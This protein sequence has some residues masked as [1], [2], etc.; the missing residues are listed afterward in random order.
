M[1]P[2]PKAIVLLSIYSEISLRCFHTEHIG[3]FW[4]VKSHTN[5]AKCILL[6]ETPQNLHGSTRAN[7]VNLT[8]WL[9]ALS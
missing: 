5:D 4:R 1:L 3:A 9:V 6:A 8:H 2:N 7:A